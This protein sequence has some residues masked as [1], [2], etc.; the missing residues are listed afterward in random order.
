MNSIIFILFATQI[1]NIIVKGIYVNIYK[2][3]KKQNKYLIQMILMILLA[4]I[5]DLIAIYTAKNMTLVAVA[6]LTTMIVWFIVCEFERDNEIR[7]D[8]K[9]YIYIGLILL[10]Y[11]FTGYNLNPIIGL[12]IYILVLTLLS[13]ILMN[14]TTKYLIST[15]KQTIMEQI[16][17]FRN[18][19]K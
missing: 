18:K 15:A 19:L 17:I 12:I 16:K 9:E 13:I 4:T 3:Q 5:L 8:I 14:K 10:V 6:T 7:F 1:F 11:I 2:S